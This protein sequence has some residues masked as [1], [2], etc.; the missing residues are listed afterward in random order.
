MISR[1]P[2][3]KLSRRDFVHG[4]M[5][6]ALTVGAGGLLAACGSSSSKSATTT[7]L[8]GGTPKHGGTL[9]AG[10]SGGGSA[11]TLD[12]HTWTNLVDGSRVYNLY[13]SLLAFDANAQPQLSLAEEFTPNANATEWTVR[14][15]PHVTFHDGKPLTADDVIFS[16]RRITNPKSPLVGA[17]SLAPVDVARMKKLDSLTVRIPCHYPFA[18]L[19][20]LQACY[21]F[22]IVPEGFDPKRPVGTGPFKFESFT[23]GQQ[24]TF[25]RNPNYWGTAPYVDRLIIS[26]Y[27][28]ESSQLN[29]LASNQ[30]DVIDLLSADSIAPVQSGG[31]NILIANGGGYTPFTMRV[32]QPPFNDVR[33]RQAFRL[34][35]DREQMLKLIFG[36]HGTIG[37]DLF[38]LYDP[39]YN[40]SLPQRTQ[41]LEQA[42]SL[43]KQAG[44]ENLSVQLVTSDIG[45]GTLKA[46][47]V[48]AQQATSAGVKVSLKQVTATE[49]F[50]PNYLKWTFAQDYWNYYPFFPNA[51][52]AMVPGAPFNE[53]HLND[54]VY[55]RLLRQAVG[56][57][58]PTQRAQLV[59]EL[60]AREYSGQSSGYIIPYFPPTIDGYGKHVRGLVP[61]KTG[62]PLGTFDF[63]RLWIE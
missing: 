59:H 13:D 29:A 56:T 37:N 58:D 45:A 17:T 25:V 35:V 62:L 53:T 55:N 15:R 30:V 8:T 1:D 42:K 10:L 11:D 6:G 21:D 14:L 34:I 61:S 36:G 18:G 48:F 52:Q 54:P 44:H 20:E 16:Y 32:D 24:S 3:G 12:P 33:V 40:H 22:F 28:D 26:D 49:F 39:A 38:G 2:D 63:K 51:F 41:D 19:R 50:G 9:R 43:L 23:P 57:V 4:S 46:A 60:Q 27:S 47:Q 31:G 5:A 7:A